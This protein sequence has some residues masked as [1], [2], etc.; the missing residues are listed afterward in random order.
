MPLSTAHP[1][2]AQRPNVQW[3]RVPTCSEWYIV[4]SASRPE[5]VLAT[6]VREKT[7]PCKLAE[8]LARTL[9]SV[10]GIRDT[11]QIQ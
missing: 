7:T 3:I 1:N 6:Q 11:S 4:Y 8:L 10:Q 9:I 5:Q 2:R